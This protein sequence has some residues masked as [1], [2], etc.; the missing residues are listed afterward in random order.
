MT[1]LYGKPCRM[2]NAGAMMLWMDYTPR[3]LDEILSHPMN[4]EA[5]LEQ[6]YRSPTLR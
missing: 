4:K 5:N 6:I 2:F 3:T 1:E